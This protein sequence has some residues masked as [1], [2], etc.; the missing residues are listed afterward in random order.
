M[1]VLTA[2]IPALV[3]QPDFQPPGIPP[4]LGHAEGSIKWKLV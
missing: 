1:A 3:E 4:D 2:N